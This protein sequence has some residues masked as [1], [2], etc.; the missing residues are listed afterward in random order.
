MKS[1]KAKPSP[2]N[3]VSL[4]PRFRQAFVFAARKHAEQRKKGSGIPYISHLMGVCSL[5]LEAGGD[6][7]IAIAALLHDVVEDCGGMPILKEVRS[8]F[9]KR[10]AQIVEGCTDSYVVP[11]LPWKKRKVDYIKHL[12][13]A[14]SDVRL[15]SSADKLHN[16]RAILADYKQIGEAVWERFSGGRDGTLWYYRTLAREFHRG[17]RNPLVNELRLVVN[18]LENLA[19]DYGSTRS[20]PSSDGRRT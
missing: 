16:A 5:V 1:R 18:E 17:S 4:G 15:V 9:G 12:K 7:D 3:T 11:K 20:A 8:R 6:E 10:V 2:G 13:T 14:D 19:E